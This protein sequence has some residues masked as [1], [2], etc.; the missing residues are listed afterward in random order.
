MLHYQPKNSF[1]VR[2]GLLTEET[3][4]SEDLAFVDC[5]ACLTTYPDSGITKADWD[6]LVKRTITAER[7]AKEARDINRG[8]VTEIDDLRRTLT[9]VREQ[10]DG[11]EIGA[12]YWRQQ[13]EAGLTEDQVRVVAREEIRNH[14]NLKAADLRE[15]L[16]RDWMNRKPNRTMEQAVAHYAEKYGW[17][18]EEPETPIRY[19]AYGRR[20]IEEVA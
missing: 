7:H 8:L 11:A 14:A 4:Y 16:Y 17:P 20:I 9:E 6:A 1:W 15:G 12:T 13:A 18:T 3:D 19:D 5:L 10:R 2:C